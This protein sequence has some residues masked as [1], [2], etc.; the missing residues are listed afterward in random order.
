[1][2]DGEE[3]I[4]YATR[5]CELTDYTSPGYL[6]TL[7]ASHAE[8]GRF[9][10]AVRWQEKAIKLVDA[11]RK[12]DYEARLEQ[13]EAGSPFREAEEIP[14]TEKPASKNLSHDGDE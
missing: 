3:A 5:A 12:A 13:Y 4:R 10:D 9:D 1:M 6:D 11:D 8:A 7:A 14:E 2:R